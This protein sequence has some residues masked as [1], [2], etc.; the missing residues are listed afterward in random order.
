MVDSGSKATLSD[1]QPIERPALGFMLPA[2]WL[3]LL[4]VLA[5]SGAARAATV[6]I[7]SATVRPG[8]RIE[9]PVLLAS[10]GAQIAGVQNDIVFDPAM[11][12]LA[13]ASDCSLNPVL[14]THNPACAE[15]SG[16]C[17]QFQRHLG[18]CPEA[19]GCPDGSAGLRRFRGIIFSTANVNLIPD[20]VLYT[21]VLTVTGSAGETALLQNLNSA[22]SDPVG[23]A[24]E[25]AGQS[26]AVSITEEPSACPGDCDGDLRITIDELLRGVNIALGAATV[27][28]CRGFDRDA[29]GLVRIDELL[30]AVNNALSGCPATAPTPTST[31]TSP[32]PASTPTFTHTATPTE[33]ATPTPTRTSTR[34]HTAVSATG[35]PL[36]TSTPPEAEPIA[37]ELGS[38][39]AAP[40]ERTSFGA[41]L[42]THGHQVVA[43]QNDI[44]FDPRAP[45]AATAGGAPAC[46]ANPTIGKEATA[47]S[48]L[49]HGC[50]P[51]ESCEAV[52]AVVLSL[53]NLDAIPDGAELYRCDVQVDAEA[54]PEERFSLRC[55]LPSGSGPEGESLV[56]DCTDGEIQVQLQ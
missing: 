16:P 54:A 6:T 5:A 17:K 10:E 12:D 49:P 43:V 34:T 25:T 4:A 35:T 40:G 28:L 20:G 55:D 46:S 33:T 48:F 31:P 36:P 32:L 24:V 47:F 8:Q 41:S 30:A 50:V 23:K 27:E 15:D 14:A 56:A 53:D 51:G 1:R 29:D 45:V 38:A 7:T 13:S 19:A 44:L 22:S 3:A 39:H 26:G 42:S 9:L 11:L 52:R 2:G 21:C 18:N 37:I